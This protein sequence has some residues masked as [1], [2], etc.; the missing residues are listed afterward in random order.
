MPV[1]RPLQ[2]LD[3]REWVGTQVLGILYHWVDAAAN[4]GSVQHHL[5]RYH[6]H[7]RALPCTLHITIWIIRCLF[8]IP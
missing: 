8:L 7:R 4:M 2:K 1:W 6:V 3:R 5:E